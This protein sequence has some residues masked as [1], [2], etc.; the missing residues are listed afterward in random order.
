MLT[1]PNHF[2][3]PQGSVTGFQKYVFLLF[4]QSESDQSVSLWILLPAFLEV[5]SDICFLLILKKHPLMAIIF[6]RLL[7]GVTMAWSSTLTLTDTCPQ[8]PCIC[9]AS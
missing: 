8:T 6:Q 7:N 4:D 1:P 9:P 3:V 5:N 2:L